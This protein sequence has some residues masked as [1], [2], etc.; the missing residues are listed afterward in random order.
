MLTNK[1]FAAFYHVPEELSPEIEEMSLFTLVFPVIRRN[2]ERL[3]EL[4][5][6]KRVS[7]K[8][9][10]AKK[11]QSIKEKTIQRLAEIQECIANNY[12]RPLERR[13]G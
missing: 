13:I 9:R 10:M 7:A 3:I 8:D 11:I 12:A 2:K 1:E 5:G 4:W 6:V